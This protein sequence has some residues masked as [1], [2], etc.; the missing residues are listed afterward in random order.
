MDRAMQQDIRSAGDDDGE[1]LSLLGTELQALHATALPWRFKP[2]GPDSFPPEAAIAL[3]GLPENRFLLAEVGDAPAGYVYAE[4]IRRPENAIL[5]AYEVIYVHHLYVRPAWQ[6]RGIGRALL[7]AVRAEGA[8]EGI[9]RLAL[10]VWS[11]NEQARAF[12]RNYGLRPYTERLC[13][14]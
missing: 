5:Q 6:S 8:K 3:L 13:D 2:P 9:A 12:F 7:D 4:I 11:F 1:A 14:G 10:D